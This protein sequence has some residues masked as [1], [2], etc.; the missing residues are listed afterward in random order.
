MIRPFALAALLLIGTNVAFAQE[1][2]TT[3]PAPTD[4]QIDASANVNGMSKQGNMLTGIY[5]TQAVIDICAIT[6]PEQVATRMG[7]DRK[8]FETGV[9]LDATGATEA[10]AKIKTSVTAT[11]PDCTEGSADRKNVEAV[12]ALYG[13]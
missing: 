5:A 1:A 4:I 7:N 2:T 10:Y 11:A 13:G 3:T 9:G 6:V 12:L 8:R